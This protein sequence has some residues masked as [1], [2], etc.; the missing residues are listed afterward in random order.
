MEFLCMVASGTLWALSPLST[1]SDL[2]RLLAMY[3]MHVLKV[4]L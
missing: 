2:G 3:K 1:L 4:D